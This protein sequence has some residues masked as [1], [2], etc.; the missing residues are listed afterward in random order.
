MRQIWFVIGGQKVNKN[1]CCLIY[2]VCIKCIKS[3]SNLF[4]LVVDEL[5]EKR[6]IEL[7]ITLHIPG[8]LH[9]NN[10]LIIY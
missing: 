6:N 9:S 8:F 1:L 7:V 3:N 2:T 10:Q 5:R 4:L